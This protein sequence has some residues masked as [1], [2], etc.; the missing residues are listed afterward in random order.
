GLSLPDY[1][2]P[3][4]IVVIGA[5]PLTANGKLDRKALP[6]PDLAST[7]SGRVPRTPREELLCDLFAEILGL[8]RVGIDDGFFDLG[9]HSLLAVRLMSR[10]RDALGVELS[11]GSLFEAPT[12]AGL[13]ERL[14][15]GSGSGALE[16]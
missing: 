9:G 5:L 15:T 11:I 8:R 13:A 6:A 2:V 14:E 7:V 4:A 10:I 1:M 12:V 16:V 3:S